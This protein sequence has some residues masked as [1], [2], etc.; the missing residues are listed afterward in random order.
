MWPFAIESPPRAGR[1]G[2][3][4]PEPCLCVLGARGHQGWAPMPPHQQGA[5][6]ALQLALRLRVYPIGHRVGAAPLTS[7]AFGL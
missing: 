7:F 6:S 4:R 1:V 2:L 5:L 3:L